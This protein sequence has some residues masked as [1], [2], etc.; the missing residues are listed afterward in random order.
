MVKFNI[1]G[2]FTRT[3]TRKI[4]D[5]ILDQVCIVYLFFLVVSPMSNRSTFDI[6]KK[7]KG[8]ITSFF[9]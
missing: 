6:R 8:Q 1:N 9:L 3:L 4:S 5:M 7:Q 2:R